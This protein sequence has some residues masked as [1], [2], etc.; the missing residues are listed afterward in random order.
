[1]RHGKINSIDISKENT[2]SSRILELIHSDVCEPMPTTAYDSSRYFVIFMDDFSRTSM[3]YCIQRKSEVLE[4]FEKFVAMAE[5]LHG[6]KIAK[7]KIDNSGKYTSNE[8]KQFC[9]SNGIQMIATVP[10]NPEMNSVDERL[11]RIL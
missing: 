11:N 1:M 10:Y 6:N 4:S 8:F 2:R 9:K 7:L 3:V 5:T